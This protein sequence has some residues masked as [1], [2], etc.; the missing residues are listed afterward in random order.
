MRFPRD[1]A[2]VLAA[3]DGRLS[4]DVIDRLAEECGADMIGG[5]AP[6][7]EIG[8]LEVEAILAL[9]EGETDEVTAVLLSKLPPTRAAAILAAL[10]EARADA[11][12]AAFARTE[13]VSPSAVSA[14]GRTLARISGER[15]APAFEA[16][17]VARVG[18]ILNAAT[19]GLRR[20]IL[21]RLD[22]TDASFAARVRAAI[23]SFENIP[24]RVAARDVPKVLRAVD[25]AR[26]IVALK[27]LPPPM[28]PVREF[29]L[30][31][32][33]KR[34]AEQMR[35]QMAEMPDVTEDDAE[36]AMSEIVAAIRTLQESGEL[37]L[38]APAD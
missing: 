21:E 5:D 26:V 1:T 30:E 2:Q 25:N 13:D 7:A 36:A 32:L 22:G 6:W 27:G 33:S 8:G 35:E 20:G 37:I 10:P 34:M 12:A 38:M 17:S 31:S 16:E 11:V 29:L 3:L 19:S 4:I 14:I 28:E 15:V 9:I 24:D 18:D 23:F